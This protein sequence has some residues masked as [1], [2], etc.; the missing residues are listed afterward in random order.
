MHTKTGWKCCD[1]F[2][3]ST[4][5]IEMPPEFHFRFKVNCSH[6]GHFIRWTLDPLKVQ[7]DTDIRQLMDKLV[8]EG[9]PLVYTELH[10]IKEIRNKKKL[11]PG[12]EKL[13][14][15]LKVKYHNWLTKV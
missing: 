1:E 2:D 8:V 5:M 10:Y 13:I 4:N 14:N 6:C 15:N 12:Q 7:Q 3:G 11:T 9:S